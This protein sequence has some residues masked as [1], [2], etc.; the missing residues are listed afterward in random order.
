MSPTSLTLP[1]IDLSA[2]TAPGDEIIN[3]RQE[4][5][6]KAAKKIHEAC[7]DVGF[8]YLTG[9]NVPQ[10]I[11]NQVLK[12]GNE[13]FQLDDKEKMKLSIANEDVAR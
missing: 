5:K 12:L 11:C 9:H 7:R 3:N 10:E 2:F 13:F 4:L 8:F 1:I 6:I